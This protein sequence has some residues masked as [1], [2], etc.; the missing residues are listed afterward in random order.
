MEHSTG[1]QL[2]LF[3]EDSP[4][5]PT[6]RPGSDEARRMTVHSGRRCYELYGRHSHLGSLAR[7]LLESN[8]WN[9][10]SVYLTWKVT[11]TASKCL[12]FR[13][14]ESEPSTG[15]T[16]FGLLPT[17]TQQYGIGQNGTRGDGTTFAQAGKPSLHTMAREG[18][19]PTP[20]QG[21]AKSSGS[22]NTESSNANQGISLTDWARQDYGKG[23]G[24]KAGQRRD[25]LIGRLNPRFVEQ[26]M[27]FPAGWTETSD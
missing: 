7:T 23:R 11:G 3:A 20:T 9:S 16:E 10:Q 8:T 21:D 17:I 4:A 15:D 5:S 14:V 2:T 6:L 12:I 13:L 26:M 18:L 27:G 19:I 1:E 25:Q 24:G 22:R